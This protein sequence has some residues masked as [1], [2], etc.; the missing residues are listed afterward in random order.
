M[1]E[2]LVFSLGELELLM[3]S[4]A[5]FWRIGSQLYIV[6]PLAVQSPDIRALSRWMLVT[7]S[8]ETDLVEVSPIKMCMSLLVLNVFGRQPPKKISRTSYM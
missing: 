6:K 5:T 4:P 1:S 8:L 3:T 7:Y 2:K